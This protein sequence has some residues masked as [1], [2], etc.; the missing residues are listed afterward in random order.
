MRILEAVSERKSDTQRLF[1][2]LGHQVKSTYFDSDLLRRNVEAMLQIAVATYNGEPHGPPGART[3]K[4]LH[5]GMVQHLFNEIARD[6]I[7][8][9]IAVF[10]TSD[11][12]PNV[13]LEMGVALTWGIRCF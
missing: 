1:T 9:D 10:E 11:L 3:H 7:G 5:A 12:N 4:A 2:V 6:I 13:M 8:S